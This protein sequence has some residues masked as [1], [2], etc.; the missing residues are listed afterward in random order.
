MSTAVGG[1]PLTVVHVITSLTTGGAER[2]LELL[3]RRSPHDTTTIA[4]YEGGPVADSM[5]AAGEA[6][7]MLGMGGWRKALAPVRLAARLRDL[8]TQGT[9]APGT[10]INEVALCAKLGVSRTP[11][12]EAVR[13][14]A[15][16]GL[17]SW[18]RPGARW[19]A[20]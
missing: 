5:R 13:M 18:C 6:V 11:L 4:L 2:Q 8:I 19:C 9:I 15:G 14:L 12:R 3:V 20:R 16:E 7:E 10:R 1:G 17:V